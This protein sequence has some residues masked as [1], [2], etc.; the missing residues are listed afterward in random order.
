MSATLHCMIRLHT[1][2]PLRSQRRSDIAPFFRP[3]LFSQLP[4]M[5]NTFLVI[6]SF[7]IANAFGQELELELEN[8]IWSEKP[9]HRNPSIHK[10]S[11]DNMLYKN[12]R[13]FVYDYYY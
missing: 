7:F 2:K 8:G 4:Q 3:V 11:L 13:S 1:T 6:F 10:Y 5:K 9:D 12:G